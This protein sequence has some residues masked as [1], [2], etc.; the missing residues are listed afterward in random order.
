VEKAIELGLEYVIVDL[1][2]SDDD[3]FEAAVKSLAWLRSNFG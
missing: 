1:D 3:V 2:N